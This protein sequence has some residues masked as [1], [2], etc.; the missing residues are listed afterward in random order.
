MEDNAWTPSAWN[1]PGYR[2]QTYRQLGMEYQK[3]IASLC[4][5]R[6]ARGRRPCPKE[7]KQICVASSQGK[8]IMSIALDDNI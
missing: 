4:F 5:P 8:C 6:Q 1:R 2:T 7:E 3:S